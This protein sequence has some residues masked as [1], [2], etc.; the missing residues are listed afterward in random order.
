MN[1]AFF[2]HYYQ[3]DVKTITKEM[4]LSN[5]QNKIISISK[6]QLSDMPAMQFPGTTHV[7]DSSEDITGAIEILRKSDVIGF[8]TE[9]RPSFRKGQVNTVS[10]LQLSTRDDAFLFRINHTG[11]SPIIT[12]LLE[13]PSILKIGVSIHDDFHNLNKLT[14]ISP[15]GFID[16]QNYVKQFRI[17]DNSLSRIYAILFGK[18]ISK[19]QR[20][21]N[22]EA[23]Q[24]SSAQ[25]SYA[26][27]DAMA[28]VHIYDYLSA[29]NFNPD[30]SPYLMEISDDNVLA[31]KT[32]DNPA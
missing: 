16:L 9:T 4:N 3:Y 31:E 21:T 11:I 27:L 32:S 14:H 25:Q 10:L 13:D 18:R 19:G 5:Q 2:Q 12:D 6:R 15:Q 7:I 24:L 30:E 17:A 1:D 22:W 28:C 23:E 29:G 8:D 20:L 26:A